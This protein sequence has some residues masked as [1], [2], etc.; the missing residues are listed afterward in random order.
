MG[1]P[2]KA[3]LG[4]S[5]GPLSAAVFRG[6]RTRVREAAIMLM[7]HIPEMLFS[8]EGAGLD[9]DRAHSPFALVLQESGADVPAATSAVYAHAELVHPGSI[10]PARCR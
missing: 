6:R 5:P 7:T 8:G 3:E 9:I 2:R 1:L 4:R 10:S